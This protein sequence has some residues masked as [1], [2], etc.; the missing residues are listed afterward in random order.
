MDNKWPLIA[1]NYVHTLQSHSRHQGSREVSE[2]L[3]QK[4]KKKLP[5]FSLALNAFQ[6]ILQPFLAI[7]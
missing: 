6:N 3:G 4:R 1:V 7:I 5:G 2:A